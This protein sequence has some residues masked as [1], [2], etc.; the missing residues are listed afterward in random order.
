MRYVFCHIGYIVLQKRKARRNGREKNDRFVCIS[1]GDNFF[2]DS[3]MRK[4]IYHDRQ[5]LIKRDNNLGETKRW[6]KRYV[7]IISASCHCLVIFLLYEMLRYNISKRTFVHL[8]MSINNRGNT[9]N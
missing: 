9:R 7:S 6:E 2:E 5:V 3:G 1:A 8:L 4:F